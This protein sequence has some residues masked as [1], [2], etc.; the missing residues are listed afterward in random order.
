MRG[1]VPLARLTRFPAVKPPLPHAVGERVGGDA[2]RRESHPFSCTS[3]SASGCSGVHF[4]P[5]P[6][7]S[8]PASR[9]REGGVPSSPLRLQ[10]AVSSTSTKSDW[11]HDAQFD[12]RRVLQG[13]REAYRFCVEAGKPNTTSRFSVQAAFAS[14]PCSLPFAPNTARHTVR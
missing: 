6:R 8:P 10:S 7:P 5:S 11:L 13:F 12:E 14:G 4:P 3:K 2:T 9:R 1:R